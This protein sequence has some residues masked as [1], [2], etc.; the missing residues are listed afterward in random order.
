MESV[1][2]Q[3]AQRLGRLWLVPIVVIPCLY[4]GFLF[5]SPEYC[6]YNKNDGAFFLTQG[7]NLAE[8]G[9]YTVD[10]FPVENHGRHA[11]WPFVF[12]CMLAAV[13]SLFGLSW[14]ALKSFMVSLGLLTLWSLLRLW[15]RDQLGWWTILILALNPV[16][17]L[18]SHHTMTEVPFL[19]LCTGTLLVMSATTT[20]RG[21]FLSGCLATVAFFTRGYAVAF[22]PAALVYYVY[23]HRSNTTL[24]AR[25]L[26]FTSFALPLVAGVVSWK[27]WTDHTIS[28]GPVDQ[29]TTEFGNTASVGKALLAGPTDALQVVYWQHLRALSHLLAP[30]TSWETIRQFDVAA[31]LGLGL[32]LLATV[33]WLR[34]ARTQLTA[35]DAWFPFAMALFAISGGQ[36]R[37]W[38]TFLPFTLYYILLALA[39]TPRGRLI[40]EIVPKLAIGLLV[41]LAIVGLG[42]HLREPSQLRFLNGYWRD[43]RDVGTWARE[44][45]PEEAVI[46]AH[47][48]A[49][50]YIAANRRVLDWTTLVAQGLDSLELGPNDA[51][52]ISCPR[53]TVSEPSAQPAIAACRQLPRGRLEVVHETVHHVLLQ[54]SRNS[55]EPPP[56]GT[57]R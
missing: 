50:M 7:I 57:V 37:Y 36:P 53:P 43:Y 18:F 40:W 49:N 22:V 52:Y 30:V 34:S 29:I 54:V 25:V 46:V 32:L 14:V 9:R 26:A 12:P 28:V 17:F 3:D 19:L 15:N 47:T 44:H 33:G 51:L 1:V 2:T 31:L 27:L 42:N 55:E 16:Y 10:T 21:A 11:T 5:P 20:L 56:G 41:V 24:G 4:Y 48:P 35:C 8:L 45:L 13:I 23:R 39:H 6:V 38:L